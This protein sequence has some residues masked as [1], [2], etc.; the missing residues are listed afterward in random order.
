MKAEGEALRK[1]QILDLADDFESHV[2]AVVE[3]GLGQ[4]PRRKAVLPV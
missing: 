2:K 4:F 1:K 3:H